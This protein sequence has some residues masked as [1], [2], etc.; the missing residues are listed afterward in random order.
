MEEN[1]EPQKYSLVTGEKIKKKS[2]WSLETKHEAKKTKEKREKRKL[3]RKVKRVDK[4][5]HVNDEQKT[6]VAPEGITGQTKVLIVRK[7]DK[8]VPV[9]PKRKFLNLLSYILVGIVAIV[10]GYFSGNFYVA[11]VLNKVDYDA[12]SEEALLP[13]YQ[14]VYTNFISSD[15]S[16][17]RYSA[18]DLF[19]A[20]IYTTSKIDTYHVGISGMIKPSIGSAQTVWGYKEKQGNTFTYENLSVGMLSVGEKV[21]YDTETKVTLSYK[22]TKIDP[23]DTTY[24]SEPTTYDYAAY[25]E[26][27][28]T[29]PEIPYC[30]YIINSEKTVLAGSESVTSLG[31]NKYQIAFALAPDS[32]VINYVKQVKHMSGL[33]SYPT[34]KQINVSA[35]IEYNKSSSGSELRFISIRYD[36]SY[37][38]VYF[39]VGASCTGYLENTFT[40]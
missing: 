16:P 26:E 35:V 7:Q 4:K 10:F 3:S 34:F 8:E 37:T 39:G 22:A 25:R 9:T 28:G 23:S 6:E 18:S 5:L 32:S 31:G 24:A 27:Y 30:P 40:Y 11:N 2:M 15:L 13:D 1:E 17:A 36:E 14:K 19:V 20:T 21:V 33:G 12:F 29:D 38:V